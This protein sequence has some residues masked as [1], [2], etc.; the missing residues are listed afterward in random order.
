MFDIKK[1]CPKRKI[2]NN[3][4]RIVFFII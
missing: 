2:G 3:K 1:L 4:N